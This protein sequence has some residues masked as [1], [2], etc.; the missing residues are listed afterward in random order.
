MYYACF[1]SNGLLKDGFLNSAH[2][3]FYFAFE[4]KKERDA[5]VE[6]WRRDGRGHV[7]AIA[8]TRKDV[9]HPIACGRRFEVV[10][11][12]CRPDDWIFKDDAATR[13][14]GAVQMRGLDE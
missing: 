10:D 14:K 5:W 1:N 13:Y 3:A 6:D 11:G 8:C 12:V 9:E 7:V 2:G 4:S